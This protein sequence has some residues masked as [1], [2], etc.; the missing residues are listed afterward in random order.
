[1]KE[2]KL[3]ALDLDGTLF[4]NSGQ[5]SPANKKEIE[6][7]VKKG[8]AV[9]I[10][11]GRPFS[12][13]PFDQIKDTGIKY[14]I[15]TNGSALY[16]I[17][18]GRSQFEAALDDAVVIP[19]IN[20]IMTK[21][22]HADAFC[23]G[24][25]YTSEKTLSA[26]SKLDVPESLLKYIINTR[27]VVPDL[28]AYIKEKNL[29]VQ[30][31]TLNFHKDENGTLVEREDVKAFLMA[32]PAI[33][34]V[35]GGYNNLEFTAAGVDKG[36]GLKKLAE[37]L[38]VPMESTIAIGDT[39]NDLSIIQAAAVGVAMGNATDEV[40]KAAA[41]ITDSNTEDGVAHAIAHFLYH[42]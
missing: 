18:T 25:G 37:L 23:G 2:I 20:Y 12:G 13:L 30:K 26:R 6:N 7:A 3:I 17:E 9:V 4:D 22:I 21:D 35:C 31:M 8:I 10:S 5:I 1:M 19:I 33:N 41:Y 29:H 14:A 24:K 32:N 40:K 42:S 11:T 27:E 16:E 28:A 39:E 36:M 15:T 38:S 34:V